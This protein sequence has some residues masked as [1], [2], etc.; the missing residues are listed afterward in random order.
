MQSNFSELLSWSVVCILIILLRIAILDKQ[1]HEYFSYVSGIRHALDC[2]FSTKPALSNYSVVL[3]DIGRLLLHELLYL[4]KSKSLFRRFL[5]DFSSLGCSEMLE[6]SARNKNVAAL[7]LVW[8]DRFKCAKSM[9]YAPRSTATLSS[10]WTSS[11]VKLILIPARESLVHK[12]KINLCCLETYFV[13]LTGSACFV[14][15]GKRAT[16]KKF[17]ACSARADESI[18]IFNVS[19]KALLAYSCQMMVRTGLNDEVQLSLCAK[20]L[21]MSAPFRVVC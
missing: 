16:V 4:T 19:N 14:K 18:R 12:S 9:F 1:L 8:H 21:N 11:E 3:G 5:S 7:W 6:Q 2:T 10:M 13:P 17:D 20:V 15:N